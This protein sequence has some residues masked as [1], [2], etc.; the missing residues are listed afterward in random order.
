[1]LRLILVRHG[2]A[3]DVD[4][5]CI[6]H[7][8]VELSVM[9]QQSLRRLLERTSGN[10]AQLGSERAASPFEITSSDLRRAVQSA[11][12][13]A[14]EFGISFSSDARLREVSFGEWDGRLWTEIEQN[15]SARLS[16]WMEHWTTAAAPGGESV[17]D[18]M[19]RV[20]SWIDEAIARTSGVDQTIVVVSHAG[21]IRAAHC[22]LLRTATAQMFD[23]PV[24]HAR[25]TI[26][27]IQN[28]R[29]TLVCANS[30]LPVYTSGPASEL[31]V[32]SMD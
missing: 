9:G 12:I 22:Y 11:E 3:A 2:E 26:I 10:S 32:P 15:D 21:W 16:F 27:E 31:A 8:D 17:N 7:A 1:M 20:S 24:E 14:R 18:L 28:E 30:D 13:L 5:R 23:I 4:G 29:T 19:I 25:A 6:G